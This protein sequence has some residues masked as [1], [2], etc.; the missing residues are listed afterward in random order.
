MEY[1]GMG[2]TRGISG[3]YGVD[4]IDVED[5]DVDV[6][7]KN[8]HID[9]SPHEHEDTYEALCIGASDP[10]GKGQAEPVPNDED[11]QA[12]PHS[13][14]SEVTSPFWNRLSRMDETAL[15]EDPE[16]DLEKQELELWDKWQE[17]KKEW[18]KFGSPE[19]ISKSGNM[20]KLE[21][22]KALGDEV[23][24]AYQ[25]WKAVSEKLPKA[26]VPSS[27]KDK[28]PPENPT[29][30]T[31]MGGKSRYR[32]QD[33]G[34]KLPIDFQDYKG[35]MHPHLEKARKELKQAAEFAVKQ[36]KAVIPNIDQF[37]RKTPIPK[38]IERGTHADPVTK[39][40]VE[41]DESSLANLARV[42]KELENIHNVPSERAVEKMGQLQ[43]MLFKLRQTKLPVVDPEA[44]KFIKQHAKQV[45]EFD[46]MLGKAKS[47]A[48]L[49]QMVDRWVLQ[50]PRIDKEVQDLLMRNP[51]SLNPEQRAEDEKI[52]GAIKDASQSLMGVM[53]SAGAL[54]RSAG[55]DKDLWKKV[56]STKMAG[57]EE[58]PKDPEYAKRR[59]AA[60]PEHGKYMDRLNMIRAPKK[61]VVHPTGQEPEREPTAAQKALKIQADR[62]A[63]MKAKVAPTVRH[64]GTKPEPQKGP[65]KPTATPAQIARAQPTIRKAADKQPETPAQKALAAMD[66]GPEWTKAHNKPEDKKEK[67]PE[68]KESVW[69][70]AARLVG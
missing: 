7:A 41:K 19:E 2:G 65:V 35:A 17:A 44:W 4:G 46:Q 3:L 8:V 43:Q 59:A 10:F 11:I 18:Q 15:F 68:K 55:T 9:L 25:A 47:S 53:K 70:L 49:R 29:D 36:I 50:N 16:A 21:K 66:K 56:T 62:D 34:G 6:N 54:S 1:E 30:P 14:V 40:Q 38:D 37:D 5:E 26:D 69:H 27:H 33:P 52:R 60:S 42:V 64:G 51:Q 22:S 61:M 67:E 63:A 24:K 13:N 28:P 32:A 48:E 39:R 31:G 12:A 20:D 58:D 57:H 45:P 23:S